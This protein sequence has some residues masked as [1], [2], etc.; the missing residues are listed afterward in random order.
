MV[1]PPMRLPIIWPVIFWLV[2]FLP[3]MA[4]GGRGKLSLLMGLGSV[5]YVFS[6]PLYFLLAI[7]FNLFFLPRNR[8][9][10]ENRFMCQSCGAVFEPVIDLQQSATLDKPSMAVS[11]E[12]RTLRK[13]SP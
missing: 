2:G 1:C 9:R 3:V 4:L 5:G 11:G 12:L 10:W 7:V 8:R 6:L 13:E